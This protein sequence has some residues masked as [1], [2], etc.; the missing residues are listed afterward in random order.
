MGRLG[1]GWVDCHES[2]SILSVMGREVVFKGVHSGV[3]R[4]VSLGGHVDV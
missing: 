3:K 2:S 1:C 4:E